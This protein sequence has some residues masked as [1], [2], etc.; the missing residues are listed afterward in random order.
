MMSRSR[1]SCLNSQPTQAPPVAVASATKNK[2]RGSGNR[3]AARGDVEGC[4]SASNSATSVGSRAGTGSSS[5]IGPV[6]SRPSARRP[7]FNQRGPSVREGHGRFNAELG[8][9]RPIDFA[10]TV[11][12]PVGL[13]SAGTTTRQQLAKVTSIWLERL[14]RE[15]QPH[16]RRRSCAA[17][18]PAMPHLSVLGR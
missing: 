3:P 4:P 1:S 12:R 9:D 10:Q 11:W 15:V 17:Q 2:R 18:H 5:F 14:L 16:E 8:S 13:Q 7:G 6:S